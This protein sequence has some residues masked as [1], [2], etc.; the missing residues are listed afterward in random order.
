[1]WIGQ[2]SQCLYGY[3]TLVIA[4][5]CVWQHT[6]CGCKRAFCI[7]SSVLGRWKHRR[8]LLLIEVIL[9]DE[10]FSDFSFQF[11]ILSGNYCPCRT[12][13]LLWLLHRIKA[14]LQFTSHWN[15]SM[16]CDCSQ[17]NPCR[18]WHSR[19]F[20]CCLGWLQEVL[21]SVDGCGNAFKWLDM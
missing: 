1:M 5:S 19:V 16:Y 10:E 9:L 12:N 6:G 4:C 17:G 7:S 3:W 20:C 18:T 21:K 15:T 8:N 11:S 2:A 13:S 14:E